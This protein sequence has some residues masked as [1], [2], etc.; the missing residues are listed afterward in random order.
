VNC[1]IDVGVAFGTPWLYSS[2]PTASVALVDPL[3]SSKEVLERMTQKGRDAK[4]F[5][6]VAGSEPGEV[7][8]TRSVSLPG[9]SSLHERTILTKANDETVYETVICQT[10][11]QIIADMNFDGPFGLKIDTEGHEKHVLE[12][13][14]A[15]LSDCAF[16]LMEMSL[17]PRF[18]DSYKPSD[19]IL[20]M[21]ESGFELVDIMTN[22]SYPR[23]IDVLFAPSSFVG[24]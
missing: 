7:T 23:F 21:R 1:I 5:Y 12:G 3:A 19:I 2:F 17:R 13:A 22:S 15:T 9:R 18:E 20:L 16:V 6:G 4:L 11:D 14:K 8:L 24:L 10:L